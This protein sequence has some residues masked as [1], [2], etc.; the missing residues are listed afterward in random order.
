MLYHAGMKQ[1]TDD[2]IIQ[3]I[4]AE[5][6]PDDTATKRVVRTQLHLSTRVPRENAPTP[7]HITIDLHMK[8]I[9]EAWQEIIS[10]AT[11]GAKSATIIT[12][13]S[14]VLHELFP[15]WARESILSPHIIE[16]HPINNGS[17][18]VRF[19]KNTQ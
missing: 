11:S 3:M 4:G 15:Q 13:A 18:A 5:F 16:F 10:A 1:L 7:D 6:S 12:G 17:F 8:T 19:H 14:G 9:E 2:D